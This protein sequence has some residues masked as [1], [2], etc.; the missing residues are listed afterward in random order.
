MVENEPNPSPT[1]GWGSIATLFGMVLWFPGEA[2]AG[3][4][5]RQWC[6]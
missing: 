5:G 3:L 2:E 4:V 6:W 1:R